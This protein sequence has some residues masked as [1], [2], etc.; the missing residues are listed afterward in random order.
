MNTTQA[1]NP[2]ILAF[3]HDATDMH[4][5]HGWS[6]AQTASSWDADA[7]E[8]F[9]DMY[10]QEVLDKARRVIE[11]LARF[12]TSPVTDALAALVAPPTVTTLTTDAFDTYLEADGIRIVFHDPESRDRV[13]VLLTDSGAHELAEEVVYALMQRA[14]V[15]PDGDGQ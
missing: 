10:E 13:E 4:K 6:A 15:R 3:R 2:V 5:A 8:S 1:I 7:F 11:R 9:E 12:A 14:T